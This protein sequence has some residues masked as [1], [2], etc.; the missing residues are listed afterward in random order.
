MRER[1]RQLGGGMQIQSSGNGTSIIVLLPLD[2]KEIGR[3][4]SR[5]STASSSRKTP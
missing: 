4:E 5:I 1:I 2:E 3:D